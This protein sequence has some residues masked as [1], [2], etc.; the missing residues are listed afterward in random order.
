MFVVLNVCVW[1]DSDQLCGGKI[2]KSQG[3]IMTPN[4]P[5]NKYPAGT[6]CSW[7]ITVEPDMV[8]GMLSTARKSFMSY[9]RQTKG[10]VHSAIFLS[11]RLSRWS[12]TSS[13]WRLTH[14]ADLT[15][16]HFLMGERK[17]IHIW[18]GNS[19]AIRPHS[20]RAD[21]DKATLRWLLSNVVLF[22]LSCPGL[23]YPAVMWCWCSLCPTSVWHLTASLLTIPASLV[24]LRYQQVIEELAPDLSLQSLKSDFLSP[25]VAL[26]LPDHPAL[27]RNRNH[28]ILLETGDNLLTLA[29]QGRSAPQ[30]RTGGLV[31]QARIEG[32]VARVRTGE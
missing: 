6:S 15:M 11:S 4:W 12:S 9:T 22:Y 26:A 17:M 18:L 23:S 25:Y 28:P 16:W 24:V 29:R 3:E 30:A 10:G 21:M 8:S 19:A 1:L 14:T 5:D 2:T 32:S 31:P 7:L 13:S 27:L 20:K